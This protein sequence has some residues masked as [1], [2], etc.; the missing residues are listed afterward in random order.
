MSERNKNQ[1][2][3]RSPNAPKIRERLTS[4]SK[5]KIAQRNKERERCMQRNLQM[6]KDAKDNTGKNPEDELFFKIANSMMFL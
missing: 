5:E 1:R 4:L 3:Y 6:Q 2:V